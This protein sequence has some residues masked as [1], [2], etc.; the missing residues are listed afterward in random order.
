MKSPF[1]K[2]FDIL[3]LHETE[4]WNQ[5]E[6]RSSGPTTVNLARFEILN[7]TAS[8]PH[9]RVQDVADQL[10]ITVGAASRLTDRIET[11][12]LVRRSPHPTDRRSSKIEL[13]EQGRIALART[14]SA[15]EQALEDLLGT[16]DENELAVLTAFLTRAHTLLTTAAVVSDTID[17]TDDRSP[18]RAE[19]VDERMPR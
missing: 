12:G 4:L 9:C 13:T 2:Y 1:R 19:P 16:M 17:D 14:E 8:T 11:D 10:R 5:V 15:V 6:R 3:V 7:A 18:A